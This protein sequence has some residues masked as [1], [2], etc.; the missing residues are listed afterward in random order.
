MNMRALGFVPLAALIL[1]G[2]PPA[3]I[4]S[5]PAALQR[6]A[7]NIPADDPDARCAPFLRDYGRNE[8]SSGYGSR[9]RMV[10]QQG[11]VP[12]AAPIMALHHAFGSK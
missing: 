7:R 1:T 8:Y 11:A 10:R 5:A 6:N 4:D 3:S 9:S 2:L 12:Q